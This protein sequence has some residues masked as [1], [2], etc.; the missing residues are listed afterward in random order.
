V[1]PLLASLLTWGG[2]PAVVGVTAI[3]GALTALER[4]IRDFFAGAPDGG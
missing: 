3:L 1:I 4:P 2:W